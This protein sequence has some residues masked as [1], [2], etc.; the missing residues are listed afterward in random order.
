MREEQRLLRL[1]LVVGCWW[2]GLI[3]PCSTR[4]FLPPFFGRLGYRVRP[5]GVLQATSVPVV[6]GWQEGDR[7]PNLG[8]SCLAL[9]LGN[10]IA[11]GLVPAACTS[12]LWASRV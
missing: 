12:G 7:L 1:E 4:L 2:H 3:A 6:S 10:S 8:P 11:P 5:F 9:L